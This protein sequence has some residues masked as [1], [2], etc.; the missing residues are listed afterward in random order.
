MNL[1]DFTVT[2]MLTAFNTVKAEAEERGVG[3]LGSELIGLVP[4]EALCQV[5]AGALQLP[6][7]SAQQVLETKL[8][9][10]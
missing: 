9:E 3:V 2:G 8:C 5:A 6:G 1:T 4:L 10:T 7:L